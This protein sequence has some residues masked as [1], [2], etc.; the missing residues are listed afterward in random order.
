MPQTPI[1]LVMSLTNL[2][3]TRLPSPQ[4]SRTN[5]LLASMSPRNEVFLAIPFDAAF[6]VNEPLIAA[7]DAEEEDYRLQENALSR[8]K[9]SSLFLG[10]LVGFFS[11]FSTLGVNVLVITIWSE[12]VITT[13]K[14]NI[15]LLCS[16][17]FSAILFAI[18]GFLRNLVAIT[19]SAIG[20]RSKEL[21]A[22]MVLHMRCRFVVGV[23]IGISLAWTMAAVLFGM[24]VQT[25]YSYVIV[26]MGAFFW[27]KIMIMCFATDI[28]PSSSRRSTVEHATI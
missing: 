10:L 26:L 1:T 5:I 6:D 28:K 11:Q 3:N 18:L 21:L 19:Y 23:M 12:D 25:V 4:I 8:F 24:R 27:C 7:G 20:G 16:F 15:I 9:F 14:S 2:P 22:E 13:S 17:F